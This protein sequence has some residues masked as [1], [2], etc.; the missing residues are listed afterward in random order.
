[1][2]GWQIKKSGGD[3]GLKSPSQLFQKFQ[4]KYLYTHIVLE[5]SFPRKAWP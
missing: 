1:M 3:A 2:E 4:N 5:E